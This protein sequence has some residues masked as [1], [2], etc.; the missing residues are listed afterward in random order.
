MSRLPWRRAPLLFLCIVVLLAACQPSAD[1]AARAI[2]ACPAW[3]A[4]ARIE[5]LTFEAMDARLEGVS[6]AVLGEDGEYTLV[7]CQGKIVTTYQGETREWSVE[8]HPYRAALAGG[9]WRMCGYG[10]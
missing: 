8:E 7:A 10:E 4:Q 3:E 6:C 5:A 2:V 9:E 1:G